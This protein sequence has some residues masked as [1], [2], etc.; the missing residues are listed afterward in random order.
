MSFSKAKLIRFNDI[1]VCALSSSKVNQKDNASKPGELIHS[2]ATSESGSLTGSVKSAPGTFK[3]PTLPKKTKTVNFTKKSKPKPLFVAENDLEALREK[4]VECENKTKYIQELTEEVEQLKQELQNVR[5]EK[6]YLQSVH[7]NEIQSIEFEMLK[8]MTKLQKT[9]E[10]CSIKMKEMEE[11]LHN[12]IDNLNHMQKIELERANL[13]CNATI[14]SLV[15]EW[16]GKI[17]HTKEEIENTWK[18]KLLNQ[19][20]VSTAILKECQAISEYNIIQC[21]LEKKEVEKSLDVVTRN[22]EDLQKQCLKYRETESCFMEREVE[23]K[24][25]I[26]E[27]TSKL[28]DR[29]R[30]MKNLQR[31]IK[32][33]Q[34]TINNSQVTIEVLKKRLMN[35]DKDVEQLKSELVECEEKLLEYESKYWQANMELKEA[36]D[37]NEELEMQYESAIKLNESSIE[38]IKGQLLEKVRAYE[39]DVRKYSERIEEEQSF[40]EEIMRQL[41]HNFDTI[42]KINDQIGM[43]GE[44]YGSQMKEIENK[45]LEYTEKEKCW[46]MGKEELTLARNELASREEQIKELTDQVK[47]LQEKWDALE[48]SCHFYKKK[49][50]NLELEA[51]DSLQMTRKYIDLSGKYDLLLQKFENLERENRECRIKMEM[52]AKHLDRT[53]KLYEKVKKE[54]ELL[55][56]ENSTWRTKFDDLKLKK[57]KISV[58]DKENVGSPNRSIIESPNRGSPFRERN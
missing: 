4:V 46:L 52:N 18:K 5:R 22:Y 36:K 41:N 10:D 34:I 6:E 57:Y 7:Q 24:N 13:E 3:T 47:Q 58:K 30:E 56:I 16:E 19:E 51:E 40:K 26:E 54:K 20:I 48:N 33:Y 32:A 9:E 35:S 44:T 25:K 50:E 21:E 45:L 55:E 8:T 38:Q 23:L 53:Q 39:K 28:E 27:L 29:K 37:T 49:A 43:V 1:K 42:K 12:E 17:K 31:E 11:K 14:K 2:P 15:N